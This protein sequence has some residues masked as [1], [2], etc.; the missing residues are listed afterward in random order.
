[1][2][3]IKTVAH[4][5]ASRYATD[6]TLTSF[7]LAAEMGAEMI[8]TDIQQSIDG[9]IV[10]Y[11]DSALLVPGEC[12]A[13]IDQ[14]TLATLLEIPL[15]KAEHI[16]R[17]EDVLTLCRELN[18]GIYLEFKETSEMLTR[19]IIDML[20]QAHLL[21]NVILFGSRPD[22]VFYVKEVEP[23]AHTAYSYRQAGID[24]LVI[25]QACRADG[26]NLAWEDYPKPHTLIKP[27]W[28]AR[29]RGAGLRIMSWHEERASE[30]EALVALGIDDICTN[31]P[32]LS[33]KII[34]EAASRSKPKE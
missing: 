25:A 15:E 29:V 21:D 10:V 17:F 2:T 3:S 33:H 14:M 20:R 6:N 5:G 8:E 30:I 16:P 18:L 13:R 11:H 32:A 34:T 22:H 19:T 27:D 4:R 26:L 1:M 9:Q 31:D 28:L 12:E 24:P 23:K 7:R